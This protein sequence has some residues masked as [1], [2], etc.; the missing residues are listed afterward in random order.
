[1]EFLEIKHETRRD[2]AQFWSDFENARPRILGAL[3]DAVSAGLG[4]LPEVRIHQLPRMADFALWITA[5]EESLG[6]KAGEAL[7]TYE[8]NRSEANSLALDVSP[9]YE[10]VAKLAQEGFSGTV[11]E[12]F[13]RLNCMRSEGTRRSLRWPKSPSAL[14]TALRR[15]ASNLRATGIEIQFS[16]ADVRGRRRVSFAWTAKSRK[17]VD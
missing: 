5:C 17:F 1:M 8:C 7:T 11:A 2:E 10:P 16:R 15:M 12:L 9:L 4:K 3:I 14:G 6:I 13:A